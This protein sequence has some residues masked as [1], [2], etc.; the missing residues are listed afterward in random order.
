MYSILRT[1]HPE[2]TVGILLDPSGLKLC[3]TLELP[4]LNNA[5][6]IS[7]IPEGVYNVIPY[8][9][10]TKGNVWMLQN[11]HDRKDIEIHSGNDINDVRGC[12]LVGE[13]LAEN[14]PHNSKL[15]RYWITNS[16]A[17]LKKL[18]KIMPESFIVEI[19]RG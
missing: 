17:T 11:V 4:W 12:L 15:Y 18:K 14:I 3:V 1:Y 9:S 7:C 13:R 10:P 19:R 2:A 16:Q 6:D 5:S 8:Q